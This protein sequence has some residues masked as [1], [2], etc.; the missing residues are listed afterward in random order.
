M[1]RGWSV[2]ADVRRLS[3]DVTILPVVAVMGSRAACYCFAI[4][5][6]HPRFGPSICARTG[7]KLEGAGAGQRV[8]AA[9]ITPPEA[10]TGQSHPGANFPPAS[11]RIPP[12]HP[13]P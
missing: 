8:R 2:G 5:A 4:H 13:A 6:L 7:R 3:A 10:R 9:T 1:D 12:P 11:R